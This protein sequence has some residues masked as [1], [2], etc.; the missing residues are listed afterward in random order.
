MK[1]SVIVPVYNARK[2]IPTLLESLEAQTYQDF[3][4][5][6]VD[7]NSKD[8]SV[9][10][11]K[12]YCKS[13]PQFHLYHEQ[14]QGPNPARK[15]GFIHAKGT[16]IYFCDADDALEKNAFQNFMDM[17]SIHHAD[18]VIGDYLEIN[19]H[20]TLHKHGVHQ[21][22]MGK[23]LKEKKEV[24]LL[25]PC[26]WN[27]LFLRSHIKESDFIASKIGEDMVLTLLIMARSK[28][29][30][31]T[32]HIIYH[33]YITASGL[34]SNIEKHHLLD[35]IP[36][37]QSLKTGFQKEGL[38]EKYHEEIDFIYYSHILYR[39]LRSVM[40]KEKKDREEVYQK[41]KEALHEV[42]VKENKYYKKKKHYQIASKLL[43]KKGLF[44]NGVIQFGLRQ[45]FTN[46][47][48]SKVFKVLDV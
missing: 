16:Y 31:Y 2:C 7:N 47:L 26:L 43:L 37:V 32:N 38:Y 46:K 18:V 10:F 19:A 12:D 5:V 25:K 3:E 42:N 1:I 22:E 15:T 9:P 24:M 40:M 14:V 11:L 28:R 30:Y 13:H 4:V 21:L 45:L 29:I 33:Y 27:K 41:L 35:I 39:I 34:S 20:Q 17:A 36:T 48:C 8:D 23:N 44:D 6:L